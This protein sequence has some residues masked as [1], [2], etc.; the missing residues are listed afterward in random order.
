M[1]L[2]RSYW[3]PLEL[4]DKEE[5]AVLETREELLSVQ[6]QLDS[7]VLSIVSDLLAEKMRG[8]LAEIIDRDSLPQLCH[9]WNGWG[10]S[11]F[12]SHRLLDHW[13]AFMQL[14]N[15]G[16]PFVPQCDLEGDFHAG[17]SFA[18]ALMA[19]VEPDAA[20]TPRGDTLSEVLRNSSF[21]S[22]DNPAELGH[23]LFALAYADPDPDRP[24]MFL[25]NQPFAIPALTRLAV[26][27]HYSGSFDVC[28]KFHMTE[29]IC[30]AGRPHSGS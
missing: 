22:S 8:H 7:H 9:V 4:T 2:K 26:E 29:G 25:R 24:P 15:L 21:V 5:V 3:W 16:R 11:I 1:Q 23:L 10:N 17:Q 6:P 12:Q 18:Y 14:D 28:R 13:D 20:V 19:G 27:S 30:A